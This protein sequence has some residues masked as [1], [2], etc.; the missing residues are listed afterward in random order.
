MASWRSSSTLSAR[1]FC[2][3]LSSSSGS[4]PP[5]HVRRAEV[6][7]SDPSEPD[8]PRI[9]GRPGEHV[10]GAEILENFHVVGDADKLEIL[11]FLS[12]PPKILFKT[13]R[14]LIDPVLQI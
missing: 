3:W 7:V 14:G 13:A 8:S 2:I 1:R 11:Q 12:K 10:A 6:R 5:E 9:R 4:A